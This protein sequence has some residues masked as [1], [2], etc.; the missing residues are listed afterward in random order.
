MIATRLDR[1]KYGRLLQRVVPTAIETEQENERALGVIEKLLA[2]GEA[3]LTPEED[4]LIELLTQL[5]E[6]FE[7]RAYP[8]KKSTP[9]QIIRFLLQERELKPI[10]LA[11][12]VGSRG[13]VSDILTGRRS[14][15]KEQAK[16]LGEFFHVSP[17]LFI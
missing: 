16:R 9:P 13:R 17:A 8:R 11:P 3:K 2:K 6:N 1:S 15:S 10:A 5:V 12:V 4:A 14:I 7:R